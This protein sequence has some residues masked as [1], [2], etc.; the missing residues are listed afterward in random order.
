MTDKRWV[1]QAEGLS[2]GQEKARLI[3]SGSASLGRPDL[4]LIGKFCGNFYLREAPTCMRCHDCLLSHQILD[5][6]RFPAYDKLVPLLETTWKMPTFIVSKLAQGLHI[7]HK[8]GR[9]NDTASFIR[10][11]VP[12]CINICTSTLGKHTHI[13]IRADFANH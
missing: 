5:E 9:A 8:S 3:P 13:R 2:Y 4:G 6:S 12:S 1:L 10:A 7:S 11:T